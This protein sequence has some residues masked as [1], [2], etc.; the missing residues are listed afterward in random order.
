VDQVQGTGGTGL[1]FQLSRKDLYRIVRINASRRP[2]RKVAVPALAGLVFLG[3]ALD[4]KY[5]DGLLWGAGV[6]ALYWGLS[7]LMYILN[8]YASGNE[9]FFVPQEITLHDD[10]MVVTSENSTEE[11]HRPDPGDVKTA[12][13]HLAIAMGRNSLV[14]LKR[15][16]ESPEDYQ[17][18]KEWL[19][20]PPSVPGN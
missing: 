16:F 4:G 10:R 18:L 12:E 17:I 11:F 8:V 15:S 14:F 1:R 19:K 5:V 3:H 20:N 9:S 7:N 13:N 6:A 2:L